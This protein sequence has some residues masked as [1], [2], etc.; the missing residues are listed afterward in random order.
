MKPCPPC[1]HDCEA[2]WVCVDPK[3]C[4]HV[5]PIISDQTI[6]WAMLAICIALGVMALIGWL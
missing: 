1:R 4:I 5:N 3:A 2:I 6:A